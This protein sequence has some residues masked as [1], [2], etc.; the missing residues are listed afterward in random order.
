KRTADVGFEIPVNIRVT[1]ANDNAPQFINAPYV[2]NISEVTVV[3]TRVLQGVRAV[4]ADQQGAYS[5]VQ[6]SVLPG[7]HADYFVF[8]NALEGTLLLRNH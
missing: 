2:L 5:T 8:V 7:P 4:D 6:Y 3:G 1:D